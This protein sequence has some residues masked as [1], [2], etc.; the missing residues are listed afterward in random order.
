MTIRGPKNLA[1]DKKTYEEA[2][3]NP[4]LKEERSFSDWLDGSRAD[5][6][7]RVTEERYNQPN[8]CC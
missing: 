6:Y 5:A 2:K 4:K 3:R 8:R 1:I 7:V